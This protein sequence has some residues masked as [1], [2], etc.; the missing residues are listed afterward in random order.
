[1]THLRKLMLEELQRRNYSEE[2]NAVTS[3]PSKIFLD[4]LTVPRTAWVL[5]TFV[6]TRPRYFKKGSW[7]RARL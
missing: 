4:D 1:M 6:N 3:T 2:T 5:G 7:H